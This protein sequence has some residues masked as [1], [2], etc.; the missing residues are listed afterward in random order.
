[1]KSLSKHSVLEGEFW[2]INPAAFSVAAI[3]SVD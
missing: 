3:T 1:M 2:Q